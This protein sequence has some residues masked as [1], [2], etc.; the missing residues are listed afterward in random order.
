MERRYAF[1]DIETTGLNPEK[2]AIIEVAVVIWAEGSIQEVF[3]SFVNPNRPIPAEITRLT[4]IDDEKVKFSPVI[5]Q[6]R[7]QLR[8]LLADCIIV[9]HNIDFDLGFLNAERITQGQ[10]RIDTLTLA[11]IFLPELGRYDLGSLVIFLQLAQ[12]EFH[13]ALADVY[14]TLRLYQ[15][16]E[17]L[18]LAT[19]SNL[20]E[21]ITKVGTTL[22][23]PETLF[24]S[25]I[26]GQQVR[27]GAGGRSLRGSSLFAPD[28]ISGDPLPGIDEDHPPILID[29]KEVMQLLKAGGNLSHQFAQYEVRTQQLE[30]ARSVVGALNE[31]KHLIVEAG[32]GTGK[33]LAYL[34]PAAFWAHNNQRRV[35][36]STNTINLQDQLVQKDIPTLQKAL[37]FKIR[38]AVR[39]GKSNYLCGRLFQQLRHRKPHDKDEM[40]LFARLLL[41]IGRTKTGDVGEIT[42]RTSGERLAWRKLSGEN[43][44]CS[45]QECA[46]ASCPLHYARQ[47]AEMAH[48]VIVNH[49][50]LL[51]DV[52]NQNHILPQFQELIIDEGHHL[53]AA[54]TNGLGRSADKRL[55]EATL[56]D[57]TAQ[58]GSFL[59][60]FLSSLSPL[61]SSLQESFV[62]VVN[63]VQSEATIAKI[64]VDEF[65]ESL[66]YFVRDYISP[67]A[68]YS[69]SVRLTPQLRALPGFRDLFESWSNLNQI[70]A[71]LLKLLGKL[72][73]GLEAAEVEKIEEIDELKVGL[74]MNTKQLDNLRVS[75]E[76]VINPETEDGI[77]WVELWRDQLVLNV[78]PLNVGPLVE[79]YLFNQLKTV[80]ITSAT[81]RTAPQGRYDQANF[82]YLRARLHATEA[83][84]LVVG[85]PF[86]YKDSTLLYLCSD[87]PE[88]NQPGYQRYVEQAIIDVATTLKGRTLVLFTAHKHLLETSRAVQP[89]LAKQEILVY[90][91]QDGGSRRNL[92]EQFSDLSVRGV[93]FGTRSFWEG[94][95]IAGVALS[96]VIIVKL[97]FDVPTD[98]IVGARSETFTEPFMEYSIPEA[99]LRFRQGFGRLIRRKTD[100]GVVVVL[101][102]RILTKRY[103][104]LFLNALPECTV[105]RQRTDRL[106]EI[107]GRWQKRERAKTSS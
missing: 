28:R 44:I 50:L 22:G 19:S 66:R 2:D 5:S 40:T 55:L 49:S 42:L 96:A 11:S 70:M 16:L 102:K 54:V 106:P 80:I 18:A 23:W 61:P 76:A 85:S 37:P 79:E 62:K 13:H 107:I 90:T 77:T 60:E 27:S 33:S 17:K 43:A 100:E 48:L 75:L 98:P 10:H 51:S 1:L 15:A 21:E 84:E 94:V 65:F 56:D 104:D 32:T 59:S 63:T 101:D 47:R 87:I 45:S 8:T 67:K 58:K 99:V 4:G 68:E 88:P 57:L 86:N 46:E 92:T 34:V 97:P 64:R 53:E 83:T 81:L 14:H 89:V 31:Q 41:W 30:M 25:S 93:L 78:A 72:K 82:D 105:L 7:S 95:D 39:K 26:Y 103:G 24:F 9:G 20:L 69:Q 35:V 29:E 38:V 12:T 6:L 74:A 52:A 3:G 91:Q 71:Q 73:E 36:I